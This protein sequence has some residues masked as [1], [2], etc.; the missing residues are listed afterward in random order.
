MT[1]RAT[2]RKDIQGERAIPG[3][4]FIFFLLHLLALFKPGFLA[5]TSPERYALLGTIGL[6]FVGTWTC[7]FQSG[8][9]FALAGYLL[10]VLMVVCVALDS[11]IILKVLATNL[12]ESIAITACLTIL[13]FTVCGGT[14][15]TK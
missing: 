15:E 11:P 10:L 5:L 8:R 1:K 12:A 2:R 7:A 14:A 9:Y 4:V 13:F 3:L 6:L